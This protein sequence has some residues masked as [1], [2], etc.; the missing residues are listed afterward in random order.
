MASTKENSKIE[1]SGNIVYAAKFEDLAGFG[2]D[3]DRLKEAI[4][5]HAG[6]EPGE[7]FLGPPTVVNGDASQDYYK[8][9]H[10]T[11]VTKNITPMDAKV[12]DYKTETVDLGSNYNIQVESRKT[13]FATRDSVWA[14]YG[15][16]INNTLPKGEDTIYYFIKMGIN[17]QSPKVN[18]SFHAPFGKDVRE[19]MYIPVRKEHVSNNDHRGEFGLRVT[20]RIVDY[21]VDYVVSLVGQIACYYPEEYKGKHV[22]TYDIDDILKTAGKSTVLDVNEH[23]EV[24]FYTDAVIYPMKQ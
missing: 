9:Y 23:L 7:V 4:K 13:Y 17:N 24:V 2:L 22:W 10:L 11:E 18:S 20:K 8:K 1:Y 12:L 14:T 16:Y 6:E 21:K 3:F 5:T 19:E 15:H